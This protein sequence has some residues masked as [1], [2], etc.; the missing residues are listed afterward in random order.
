V[1]NAVELARVAATLTGLRP[2]GRRPS[3]NADIEALR[4]DGALSGKQTYE[5]VQLKEL[6]DRVRH[7]YVYVDAED[8]YRAVRS[9][10]KF[11]PGFMAS[12]V[13]WLAE[14]GVDLS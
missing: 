9:L 6:C 7:E 2:A 13:Q 8:V 3:T 5:I 12:Y 1:D 11:L 14:Y 4:A 10:V